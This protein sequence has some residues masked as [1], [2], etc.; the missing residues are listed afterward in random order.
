MKNKQENKE[1]GYVNI[2]LKSLELVSDDESV[3]IE[4]YANLAY[5]DDGNMLADRDDEVVLPSAIDLKNFNLNPIMLFNHSR[6]SVIG[7]FTEV[8]I[9]GKGLYVTGKVYKNLNREVYEAVKAGVLVSMSI[10]FSA[11]GGV[12]TEDYETFLF[13]EVE[14]LE[15]SVVSLPAAPGSLF[16]TV[17]SSCGATCLAKQ[18]KL[19]NK[20]INKQIKDGE[21]NQEEVK[22]LLATMKTEI[23]E[24]LTDP[25]KVEEVIKEVEVEVIKE[26]AGDPLA[27]IKT[28]EVT[29]DNLE[30]VCGALGELKT[31]VND[32]INKELEG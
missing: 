6:D 7:K 11:K 17:K 25:S 16:S 3:T 14:L 19:I 2:S 15:I 26:V 12:Y 9:T 31:L 28:I 24:E 22:S 32:F 8:N 23:L 5:D 30:A 21:M 27:G 20:S 10:G 1:T 18:T 13:T 29:A 4:G